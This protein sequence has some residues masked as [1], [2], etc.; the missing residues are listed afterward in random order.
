MAKPL[1]LPPLPWGLAV[2]GVAPLPAPPEDD[3]DAAVEDGALEPL[4]FADAVSADFALLSLLFDGLPEVLS[5]VLFEVLFDVLSD[6]LAAVELAVDEPF[7]RR[8][9]RLFLLPP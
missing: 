5:D 9:E 1:P 7:P 2:G 6:A 8:R 4:A 3:L